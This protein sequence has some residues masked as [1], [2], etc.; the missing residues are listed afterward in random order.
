MQV[1]TTDVIVV[2][3]GIVGAAIAWRIAVTAAYRGPAHSRGT[4]SC[5]RHL[6]YSPWSCSPNDSGTLESDR[7][8]VGLWFVGLLLC[9]R[10]VSWAL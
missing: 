9:S 10:T 7:T 2:G 5:Y 3:N 8:P 1:T 4:S 6:E